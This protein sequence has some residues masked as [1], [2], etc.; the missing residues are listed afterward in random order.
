MSFT[1]NTL[2]YLSF[3]Y[4]AGVTAVD[5]A[6]TSISDALGEIRISG[7][8]N[9][10]SNK[11][12]VNQ[13]ILVTGSDGQESFRVTAVSPNVTVEE[14]LGAPLVT[15]VTTWGG[16]FSTP[17]TGGDIIISKIGRQVVAIFN[18][19]SGTA[20]TAT[21]ISALVPIPNAL[22]PENAFGSPNLLLPY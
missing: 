4:P 1:P 19:I 15:H 20:D 12:I 21:T 17:I 18:S 10:V 16:A 9:E 11:F 22:H 7:Y 8:F 14:T 5:W 13:N 6:Y 3:G 2:A